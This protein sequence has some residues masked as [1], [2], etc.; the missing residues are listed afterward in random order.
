MK[1]ILIVEDSLL[2]QKLYAEFIASMKHNPIV[3]ANHREAF[4][5]MT[6]NAISLILLDIQLDGECGIDLAHK[7]QAQKSMPPIIAITA[8]S[9]R[10]RLA[11]IKESGCVD[12]I[13]KPVSV[14][15][16]MKVINK[17]LN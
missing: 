5:A 3:A 13:P 12:Y 4:I 15:N 14:V 8:Y 7:L 16:F 1:N 2:N 10:K 6:T 17:H 9:D 11:A